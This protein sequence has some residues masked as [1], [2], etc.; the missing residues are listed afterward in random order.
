[1]EDHAMP[2]QILPDSLVARLVAIGLSDAEVV[3]ALRDD[4]GIVVPARAIAAWRARNEPGT[5]RP[6]ER[7][8]RR[9]R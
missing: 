5:G 6:L 1:M 7:I 9:A 3:Q 4:Y 2:D 8:A